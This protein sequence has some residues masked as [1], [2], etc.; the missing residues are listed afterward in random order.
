MNKMR[1]KLI[2]AFTLIELLVVIA[3]IAILA[4]LLLPALAKAKAKAIRINCVNNLKQCGLAFRL[5]SGD[6]ND[7]YPMPQCG[8]AGPG[9]NLGWGNPGTIPSAVQNNA[10][11]IFQIY[12]TMSN[13]LGTPKV[14][15][16]PADSRTYKT[17]F[18]F[19][20]IGT[21]TQQGQSPGAGGVN[22]DASISFFVGR[23]CDETMP[24]MLLA[25]DRNIG[26]TSTSSGY[27]YSDVDTGNTATSPSSYANY[28]TEVGLPGANGNIPNPSTAWVGWTSK[29]HQNQGNVAFADGSAQQLSSSALRNALLKSSDSTTTLPGTNTLLFP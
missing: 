27:G 14:C 18:W 16:C 28:G 1:K 13:E 6:N 17:N 21:S 3:I 26:A 19:D 23:D 29:L 24:L 8:P 12:Q 11:W 7:H 20:F 22:G 25:G 10:W 4:G 5:W 2:G 9:P 15:V